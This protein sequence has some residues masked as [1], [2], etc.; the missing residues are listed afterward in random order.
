MG[1][2]TGMGAAG[3]AR[4][5]GAFRMR[6]AV[7]ADNL[8]RFAGAHR[9]IQ[10]T[11]VTLYR[12]LAAAQPAWQFVFF[13]QV[14]DPLDL[15][16]DRP[17]IIQRRID[18][19]GDSLRGRINLWEQVRL[20]LAAWL[21]GADVLH[22]PSNTGPAHSLVPLV[23]T[24]HDLTP[25]RFAPG[26]VDTVR[27]FRCVNRAAHR[28]ATVITP[29]QSVKDDVAST[30][31]L[32]PARIAVAHHA[33]DDGYRP[34]A[35]ADTRQV[36]AHYGED[37]SRPFVLML[38]SKTRRKNL[39]RLLEAWAAVDPV[40]LTR[41]RLL[42]IGVEDAAQA[43]YHEQVHRLGISASC[44]IHG[45]APEPH[46]PMLLSA[47]EVLCYPSMSEGFGLPILE[48]FACHTAVLTSNV[49]SMPE[50]AGAAAYL[51]DPTSTVELTAALTRMMA[52]DALR[53]RLVAEGQRRLQHFSWDRCVA[54]HARI[55][56]SA[57]NR[58]PAVDDIRHRAAAERAAAP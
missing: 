48:A 43:A 8:Y 52:D 25:V 47:A 19:K 4:E 5:S 33:V 14:G 38:G 9:G 28:A 50:V 36:L 12:R 18:I 44:R 49:T 57:A 58:R 24:I 30:C 54:T 37:G 2:M 46:M 11:Q 27:W 31:G 35:P 10:K 3:A 16:T 29:S 22:S 53:A 21:A 51:F 17:N 13:R 34:V 23:L 56:A 7:D 26:S 41:W 20:P 6:I 32:D 15:F 39:A 40:L 45:A 55:F 1:L 42:V